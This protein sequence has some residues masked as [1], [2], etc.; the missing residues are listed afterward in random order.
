ML[1]NGIKYNKLAFNELE[2]LEGLLPDSNIMTNGDGLKKPVNVVT[3]HWAG[4]TYSN[5][6]EHYQINICLDTQTNKPYLL[7]ADKENILLS[8]LH[9]HTWRENTGNIGIGYICMYDQIKYPVTDSMMQFAGKVLA[10][11]CK[12]FNLDSNTQIKDHK[13]FAIKDGYASERWDNQLQLGNGETVS[14]RTVRYTKEAMNNIGEYKEV[15]PEHKPETPTMFVDV[16]KEQWFSKATDFLYYNGILAGFKENNKLY[17]KPN[18]NLTREIAFVLLS[19][20]ISFIQIKTKIGFISTLIENQ[21]PEIEQSEYKQ[22]IYTLV[23]LGI[24]KGDGQGKF[25]LD[26]ELTRAEL[27]VLLNKVY[28][29]INNN[30]PAKIEF[31]PL[32]TETFVD[33]DKTHWAYSDIETSIQLSLLIG[34]KT[35]KGHYFYPDRKITRAEFSASVYKLLQVF[36]KSGAIKQ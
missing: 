21:I 9:S 14:S 28:L 13:Y 6:C 22:Q 19:K 36:I 15:Q 3:Q 26:S 27:S 4:S 5:P 25:H 18:L 1:I 8:Y 17:F 30:L 7:I 32:P 10:I 12:H 29:L 34:S 2:K 35:E 23:F 33:L 11:V 31:K 16:F 20:A 24:I